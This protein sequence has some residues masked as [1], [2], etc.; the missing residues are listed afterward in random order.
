M[1]V[2][3]GVNQ[4]CGYVRVA[5]VVERGRAGT[6]RCLAVGAMGGQQTHNL[7]MAL[8]GRCM[9]GRFGP[10]RVV[11]IDER[12]TRDKEFANLS[13]AFFYGIVERPSALPVLRIDVGTLG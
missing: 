12:A 5:R 8:A 4:P 9:Q 7:G 11:C 2:G 1:D 3:P 6:V 13:V 10:R